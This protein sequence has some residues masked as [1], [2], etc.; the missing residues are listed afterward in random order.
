M[1]PWKNS[2]RWRFCIDYSQ[3]NKVTKKDS[4]PLTRV[5][6]SLDLET[7]SSWTWTWG[8]A[9]GKCHSLLSLFPKLHSVQTRASVSTRYFNLG[10]TMLPPYSKGSWTRFWK[11]YLTVS[12]LYIW[13]NFH[14]KSFNESFCQ[15]LGRVAAP[16]LKLHPDKCYIMRCEVELLHHKWGGR[17]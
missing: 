8:V 14:G 5:D 10:S 17:A 3:L 1:A 13:I 16:G 7:G 4:Y 11:E 9:T 12:V 2:S 6:E 15:V